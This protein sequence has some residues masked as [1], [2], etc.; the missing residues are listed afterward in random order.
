MENI[1]AETN[2]IEGQ[3]SVLLELQGLDL[4]V[5]DWQTQLHEKKRVVEQNAIRAYFASPSVLFTVSLPLG[6]PNTFSF[7]DLAAYPTGLNH[8]AYDGTFAYPTF[9]GWNDESPWIS[10]DSAMNTFILSPASHFMVAR[11]AVL[12]AGDLVSGISPKITSL[13]RGI[14]PAGAPRGRERHQS[15]LR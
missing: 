11:T 5:H 8:I 10:F 6:G 2:T 15:D 3:F 1:A 13:S 14:R 7:P 12:P 9:Q 4:Q